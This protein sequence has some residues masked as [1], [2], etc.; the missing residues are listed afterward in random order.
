MHTIAKLAFTGLF[1]G[2][3]LMG[4]AAVAQATG[5]P[6]FADF[7]GYTGAGIICFVGFGAMCYMMYDIWF[8]D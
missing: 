2:M 4:L 1:I 3:I 5:N 7:M 8:G 6:T